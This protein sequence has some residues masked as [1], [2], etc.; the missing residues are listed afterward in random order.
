M[1]SLLIRNEV[2]RLLAENKDLRGHINDSRTKLNKLRK[3]S[4]YQE[5]LISKFEDEIQNHREEMEI[6]EFRYVTA[7]M[8][9]TE[10]KMKLDAIKSQIQELRATG[11]KVQEVL[12]QKVLELQQ[13][14][15][16]LRKLQSSKEREEHKSVQE[17]SPAQELHLANIA[18]D[19][20]KELEME[21]LRDSIRKL[22]EDYKS[23]QGPGA[24]RELRQAEIAHGSSGEELRQIKSILEKLTRDHEQLR[25]AVQ[26]TSPRPNE[27][28]KPIG[29]SAE[30]R[31]VY[32][33]AKDPRSNHAAMHVDV[34]GSALGS[35]LRFRRT[36]LAK[37]ES[38]RPA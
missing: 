27:A 14:L 16:E 31:A 19:L 8:R 25:Y 11:D 23:L 30:S 24:T 18:R 28:A 32:K 33:K 20:R 7:D 15:E 17:P 13:S 36:S 26:G 37:N 1:A 6:R 12:G 29:S 38:G 5:S 3:F 21:Q 4:R 34:Q 22:T 2:F 9:A 35:T 10:A